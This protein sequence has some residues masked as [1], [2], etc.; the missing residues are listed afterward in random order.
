MQTAGREINSDDA[1]TDALFH[2]QVDSKVF[3]KELGIVFERLLIQRVQHRMTRSV[4]RR[5]GSLRRAFAVPRCHAAEWT[6]INL[7]LLGT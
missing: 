3:D 7:A 2:D 5:A 1:T 4:S 6:L